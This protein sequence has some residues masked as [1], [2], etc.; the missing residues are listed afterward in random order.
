MKILYEQDIATL[1]ANI[2]LDGNL[3]AQ[4]T[5]VSVAGVKC[6]KQP[7]SIV[8]SW[9]TGQYIEVT[10]EMSYIVIYFSAVSS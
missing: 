2:A 8:T 1:A 3:H 7:I 10:M 9:H 6:P 5:L 4:D